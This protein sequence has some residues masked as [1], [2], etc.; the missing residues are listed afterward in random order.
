MLRDGVSESMAMRFAEKR[1]QLIVSLLDWR[2]SLSLGGV[3]YSKGWPAT[4][5]PPAA[6]SQKGSSTQA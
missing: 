2:I 4:G 5:R 1:V 6:L 3:L